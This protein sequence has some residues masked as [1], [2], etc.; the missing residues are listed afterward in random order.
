MNRRLCWFVALM[1]LLLPAASQAQRVSSAKELNA[2][3][4]EFDGK[5]V[6]VFVGEVNFPPMTINKEKK[7]QDFVV[8][9]R[10]DGYG[11]VRSEYAGNI[12]VRVPED[13]VEDFS[14]LH[15]VRIAH[16]GSIAREK[17]VGTFRAC[18]N[19]AGGYIDQTDGAAQD[20]EPKAA[21]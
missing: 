20:I 7:F 18:K 11:K 5:K 15:G 13:Q 8:S 4:E 19:R 2:R 14:R 12:V 10:E 1:G 17:I 9:T 16:S 6:Q 3:P 21:R